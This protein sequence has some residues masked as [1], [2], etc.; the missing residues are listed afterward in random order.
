[1]DTILVLSILLLVLSALANSGRA[2]ESAPSVVV[3][4][5]PPEHAPSIAA[6]LFIVALLVV[7]YLLGMVSP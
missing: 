1:M 4:A 3:M 7:L 5:S 2:R 6:E